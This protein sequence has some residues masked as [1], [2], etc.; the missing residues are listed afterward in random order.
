MVI[1]MVI[2]F[3]M[4]ILMVAYI[5]LRYYVLIGN[6]NDIYCVNGIVE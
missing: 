3:L 6:G 1:T 2:V 4:I 5:R